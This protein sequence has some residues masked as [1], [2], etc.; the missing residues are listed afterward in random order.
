MPNES[1]DRVEPHTRLD[2][3]E[4]GLQARVADPLWLLARQWQL[5]GF[6]GEDAASP[7][8]ARAEVE[9]APIQTVRNETAHAPRARP[10]VGPSLEAQ[11]QAEATDR[12]PTALLLGMEAG[13]QLLRRLEAAGLRALRAS[14][15]ARFPVEVPAEGRW[16]PRVEQTLRRWARRGIDGRAVAA[17]SDE[18]LAAVGLG[19]DQRAIVAA[20]RAEVAGRFVEPDSTGDMW[21]DERCEYGFSLG[22][23]PTEDENLVLAAMEH[24]G[25][26]LDWSAFDL[27]PAATPRHEGISAARRVEMVDVRPVPLAYAGMPASRYWE[28]EDG[29]TYFG[30]IEAGP[31]DIGRLLVAEFALVYS[32][33][34]FLTAVRAPFG[35]L[36]R[37]RSID[38]WDTFGRRHRLRSLAVKDQAEVGPGVRRP[39][40]FWE[41]TGDRSADAGQSPWLYLAP[42]SVATLSG[43]ALERVWLVR[44]EGAN[45]GWGIEAVVESPTGRPISRRQIAPPEPESV[46]SAGADWAYR[47][48]PPVPPWWVPLVPERAAPDIA[49]TT[50]RR[51]RMLAWEGVDSPF[52]G[53]VGRVLAPDRPLRLFEEEVPRGGI[54]VTRAWS[55]TRGHDGAPVLW[56]GRTKRPGRGDRVSGLRFDTVE[57]TP[58]DPTKP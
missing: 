49:Q 52:V 21:A 30:G 55:S 14:L 47:L 58:A 2:A 42:A 38:V 25:G 6:R 29:A 40:A 20:W 36:A 37:V 3:L 33:D 19:P 9:T 56:V 48:Q 16:P 13:L 51:A 34:W 27:A 11:V 28:F 32:D 50:L 53:A 22:A 15:I 57:A 23:R 17:A 1:W 4:E 44:D 43:E 54:E 35:S 46:R 18:T 39:W 12:D 26:P 5:G 41:L 7:I 31:A 24:A 45:L 8:H 10:L